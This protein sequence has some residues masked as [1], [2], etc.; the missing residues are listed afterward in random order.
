VSLPEQKNDGVP[1]EVAAKAAWEL[2]KK[3]GVNVI[4]LFVFVTNTGIRAWYLIGDN[5]EVVC[6]EYSELGWLYW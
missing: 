2:E 5:L 4:Y 3:A 6:T 1:E